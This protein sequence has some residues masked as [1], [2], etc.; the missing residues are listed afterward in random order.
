GVSAEQ[1]RAYA[2]GAAERGSQGGRARWGDGGKERV[3]DPF[4]H[5][6]GGSNA[7][8]IAGSRATTG[9]PLLANDPHLPPSLPST[10]YEVHLSGGDYHVA[11]ASVPGLPGVVIGHNEHI[12]WG[13]TAAQVDVQDLVVERLHPRDPHRYLCRGEWRRGEVVKEAIVV[14][15]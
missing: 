1:G 10:W 12:A 3:G 6:P 15:G 5:G 8:V 14:R 13:V 2:E 4:S 9:R 7:W 11:G